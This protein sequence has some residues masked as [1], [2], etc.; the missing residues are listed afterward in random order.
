[1]TSKEKV[2]EI[3]DL[4]SKPGKSA[5]WTG[6]PH[7]DTLE[8][9]L[10]KLGL[11]DRE[12]L[13][14]YLQDDCRWFS[15]GEYRDPEGRPMFDCYGGRERTSHGEAGVFAET[16]SL[17]QVEEHAWPKVEYLNFD[18]TIQACERYSGKAVF[19]GLWSPF[20]HI[21]C[22]Y[23]GMENYFTKMYTHPAIVQAVTEHVVDFF[24]EANRRCFE[25]VGDACEIFFFGND[26]GTQRDLL[27]SPEMFG[28]FVLP[29]VQKLVATAKKCGKKVLLHS[30]G[31]IARVI[32]MLIEAGIDG[33]H[34]LQARARDMDAETLARH[35]RG[36]VT[37]VGAVDTQHLLVHSTA[38]QVKQEVRRLRDLFGRHYVVSPSHEAILPNVPLD[39]VIAMSE[40]ARE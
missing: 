9:Y 25:A 38:D 33:L 14:E 34:P 8:I 11:S 32:P 19:S 5:F 24:A 1:M 30:C 26:F 6:S 21:C 16:E 23:F 10:G 37:F 2:A 40:A 29:G 31:S 36:K 39:N 4:D 7:K 35:Y 17:R 13:F 12:E 28:K 3:F 20:F 22:R 18:E 27:I 15:A